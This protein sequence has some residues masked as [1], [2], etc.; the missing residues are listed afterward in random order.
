MGRRVCVVTGS[1]A[2]YGLLYWLIKEI[3]DD[4]DLDL[5]LVA[6]GM[7]LAPQFGDTYRAIEEDGFA[8]DAKVN[9]DLGGDAPADIAKS[10]GIGIGGMVEAFTDLAPDI[11]VVLGDR[12]EIMAA[13]QAAML[14]GVPLAHIHGGELTEGAMD[15]AMRHA[16]T[17]MSH[18]HFV[19]SEL[20]RNR[21]IQ[22][23]EA[24]E[25]VF[26]VGATGLDNIERLE[27]LERRQLEES[28]DTPLGEK[29]FLVTYHP[30]TLSH[31]ESAVDE[32]V[33]A[34]DGFPDHHVLVTGVN[35]DPGRDHIAGK[36]EAYASRHP[37]R[38]SLH[39][40]LGQ[41]RYLSAMKHCAAVV[42]NSS[43]GIIEAPALKAPTVN[44]GERQGGRLRSV[45]VIDCAETRDQISAAIQKAVSAEFRDSLQ[46]ASSPY[47]TPGASRRIKDVLKTF[48]LEGIL[49]KRFHD[50]PVPA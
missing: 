23:G 38:V 20:Y 5:Q 24:P 10:M 3:V 29:F 34:L 47:G 31:Q 17:K 50:L 16:I 42:G 46:D 21:V 49:M 13:A 43:S 32:L 4:P 11:A 15:D 22:L 19:A 30:A 39:A 33:A 35:A 14:A 1:R 40:S 26:I 45:S 41:L 8:L 36:L 44:M 2:E 6:T 28:L 27:L 25:R 9:M 18:V 48:P 37:G 12:F 7:H